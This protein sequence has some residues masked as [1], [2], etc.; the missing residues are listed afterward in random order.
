MKHLRRLFLSSTTLPKEFVVYSFAFSHQCVQIYVPIINS[1]F[2]AFCIAYCLIFVT[3]IFFAHGYIIVPK[4]NVYTIKKLCFPE[5]VL[6]VT[7][8]NLTY[9]TLGPYID[10]ELHYVSFYLLQ[11]ETAPF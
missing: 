5:A 11:N 8:K 6:A 1:K 3:T 2:Y 7:N 4:S 10:T 9:R